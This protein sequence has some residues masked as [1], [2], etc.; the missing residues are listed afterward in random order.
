MGTVF[1]IRR[2]VEAFAVAFGVIAVSHLVRGWSVRDSV[3]EALPWSVISAA[4]FVAARIWQSR[5]GQHCAIC[6]D[7]PEMQD[8]AG[9]PA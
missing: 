7:T 9:P 6:R 1:W 5:R 2:Y 4:V 3:S 8:P